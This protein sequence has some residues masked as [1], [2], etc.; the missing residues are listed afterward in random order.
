MELKSLKDLDA[1]LWVFDLD[2]VIYENAN[3]AE[4]QVEKRMVKFIASR[5]GCDT[6]RADVVRKSLLKKHNTLY[7]IS[8]LVGEGFNEKEVFKETYLSI[9]FNELGVV[10]SPELQTL[11]SSLPGAKVILTNNHGDFARVV[12][13]KLGISGCFSSVYGIN[14]LG[15]VKK[16]N[17]KV[18]QLIQDATDINNNIVFIDDEPQN[19]IAA[20]EFGWTSVLKGSDQNH[21]GLCISEIR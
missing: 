2:G 10:F 11:I 7:S 15:A 8:A 5:Y 18:F 21:D 16:P 13:D 9:N 4:K 3:E 14:E 19:L 1:E 20:S 12:L 6:E 17:R